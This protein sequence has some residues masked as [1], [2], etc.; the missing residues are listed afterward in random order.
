MKACSENGLTGSVLVAEK[1][2][3][4][5]SDG[6]GYMDPEKQIPISKSTIFSTGSITKQFTATAIHYL[7]EQGKLSTTDWTCNK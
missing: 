3:V 4:L 7:A 2:Q 1:G 5:F 6:I